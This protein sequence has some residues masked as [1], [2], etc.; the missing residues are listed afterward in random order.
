MR[1]R[2]S[3][4]ELRERELPVLVFGKNR[5]SVGREQVRNHTFRRDCF[6]FATI[7]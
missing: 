2:R 7:H 1:T 5:L 3:A 4:I 6:R